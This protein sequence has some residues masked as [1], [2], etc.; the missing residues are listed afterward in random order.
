VISWRLRWR[1][2]EYLRNSIWIIPGAFAL[3]VFL[4]GREP[5]REDLEAEFTTQY[6]AEAARGLLSAM[7]SGMIAF[8]GFV[9][10][11][12]LLAI[13]FGSN[14]FSPRMLRRFL[15]DRTTKVA[16]G[17]FIATFLYALLELRW[18]G[19]PEN[20]DLVP[21]SAI[22][23][24]LLLLLASM[25]MFLRLIQRATSRLRVAAAV[26]EIGRDAS[27]V[28]EKVYPD[29][30]MPGPEP[31]I[32]LPAD[33][34]TVVRYR[35]EPAVLQSFDRRG[36]VALAAKAGAVIELVPA[37]GDPLVEGVELFRVHGGDI[38]APKLQ[39]SVAVGDERTLQ[40]D[41]AFAFRLLA[42]IS[43]KALSPGVNDPST[44]VQ[45]LDQAEAMLLELSHRRL[46]P[47]VAQDSGGNTRLL[48]AVPS[49]EDY[50][51]LALDET[52][53]FGE[54][55]VQ[56]SRRLR[57][58]L[59]RLS[60]HVPE[61]RRS[62]VRAKQELVAAGTTRAFPDESDRASAA[63]SDPQGIG[64]SRETVPG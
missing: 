25:F 51:S 10:S 30:A 62:A 35:G 32:S 45:A 21:N 3:A 34:A 16:L 36:L 33:H 39:S 12:L 49:W 48:W 20:P 2:R 19:T 43:A 4:L 17:T 63:V 15:R 44:A 61:A 47:G 58:L 41:P 9:F 53:Q 27:A 38:A 54:G 26:R 64:S 24:S 59:E 13:T 1:I 11:V 7:A 29:S 46:V 56:V 5:P 22:T 31:E 8:T 14:Q 52:R 18:V 23:L 42:D 60:D 40:Q 57:A 6:G 50:L 37:V 28:I 55:S